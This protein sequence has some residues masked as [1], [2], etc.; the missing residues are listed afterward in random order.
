MKFDNLDKKIIK[1]KNFKNK[2]EFK[3]KITKKPGI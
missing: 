1:L 3:T 2:L